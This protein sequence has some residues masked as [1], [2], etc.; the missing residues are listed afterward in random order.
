LDG[1]FDTYVRIYIYWLF[2]V[3][4]QPEDP[5]NPRTASRFG[6]WTDVDDRFYIGAAQPS[7]HPSMGSMVRN[8]RTS[9]TLPLGASAGIDPEEQA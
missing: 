9:L 5:K 1:P 4:C 7:P 8:S 6:R 3:N 2:L